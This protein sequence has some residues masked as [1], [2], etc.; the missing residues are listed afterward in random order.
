MDF[1]LF[2]NTD[3]DFDSF[4][5]TIRK[6]FSKVINI[7]NI[8]DDNDGVYFS[9]DYF[10]VTIF[11]EV[12]GLDMIEEDYKMKVTSSIQIHLFANTAE[13]GMSLLL[14]IIGDLISEIKGNSIFLGNS[15]ILIFKKEDNNIF[16]YNNPEE[17]FFEISFDD[18]G[19]EYNIASTK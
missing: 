16:V 1:E 4:Q 9:H 12:Y 19:L 8:T 5:K 3:L 6:L 13:K 14:Q 18:L 11:K 15:S 7:S 17:Y 2:F 10:S